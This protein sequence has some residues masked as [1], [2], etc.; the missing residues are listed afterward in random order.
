MQLV[1]THEFHARLTMFFECII[2]LWHCCVK[3]LIYYIFS[4]SQIISLIEKKKI[5]FYN[6]NKILVQKIVKKFN[7]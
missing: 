5:S 2:D 7:L 1:C 4:P 3:A 6:I